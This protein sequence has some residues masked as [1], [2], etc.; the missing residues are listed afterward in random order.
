MK[1]IEYF[2]SDN[3]QYWLSQ[4]KDSDWGAGKYLYEQLKE[5]KLKQLVGKNTKVLMLTQDDA[6]IAYCTFADKDDIQPTDLTP[7]IGFVYTFPQYRG[8]RYS[9]ELLSYAENL[10]K[11]DKIKN[12]Y[13]STNHI[14]L[15][16]KYGYEFF[17]TMKD[18]SGED[19]RVY[20]KHL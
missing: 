4:I 8:N 2:T 10:A 5:E 13:I 18:I 16:E 17:T 20:T 14:G 15:Y 19:S 9:G 3:K 1:I 6:L 12:I 11:E 7:W